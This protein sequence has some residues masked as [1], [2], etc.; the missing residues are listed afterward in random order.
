ML[1]AMRFV[2]YSPSDGNHLRLL[3]KQI[4]YQHETKQRQYLSYLMNL[5]SVHN[6]ENSF[7]NLSQFYRN[8]RFLITD[9][10]L[11]SLTE[12]TATNIP[13]P[14]SGD[15]ANSSDAFLHLF[16]Y[17]LHA[18]AKEGKY[19]LDQQETF[20][21]IAQITKFTHAN[22]RVIIAH[23]ILFAIMAKVLE[24][25]I[26]QNGAP[27]KPKMIAAAVD[28]AI[29]KVFYQYR[30]YQY[31]GELRYFVRLDKKI[32]N[33]A[34]TTLPSTQILKI[35]PKELRAG[36]Y[37]IDTLETV[38]YYLL[39]S[40][41][42]VD[43]LSGIVSM[44]GY[45]PNNAMIFTTLYTLAHGVTS[46]ITTA[47]PSSI[48]EDDKELLPYLTSD[49]SRAL[50]PIKNLVISIVNDMDQSRDQIFHYAS[51]IEFEFI[52][53]GFDFKVSPFYFFIKPKTFKEAYYQ[54][55]MLVKTTKKYDQAFIGQLILI[56]HI[57]N[58]SST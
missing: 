14:A 37:V 9:A 55:Y 7:F 56:N 52:R 57:I 58:L 31:L 46:D 1:Y 16:A 43:G 53:L 11:V 3:E 22:M 13:T 17:L 47:V 24:Y 28:E 19:L 5:G 10:T 6:L 29:R 45:H 8:H 36:N 12:F 33:P 2:F 20:T 25:R 21:H 30:D 44:L 32:Y 27:L 4:G 40:K 23:T 34:T 49:Y 39:T 38:I 26:H 48:F 18:Y 51:Q 15:W 41:N 54:L 42:Y 35:N 50:R